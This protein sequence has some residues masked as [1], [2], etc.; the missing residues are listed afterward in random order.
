MTTSNH[1]PSFDCLMSMAERELGAFMS[2]VTDL[3]GSEQARV[4]ARDWIEEF[5][6]M[7]ALPGLTARAWRLI[8][9]AAAARLASRLSEIAIS[10]DFEP[11]EF[12]HANTSEVKN[13]EPK[14]K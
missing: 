2:V 4:S 12:S 5:E 3:Y 13:D 10:P 8:T 7:N 9:I 14:A 11:L 1:H 6:S